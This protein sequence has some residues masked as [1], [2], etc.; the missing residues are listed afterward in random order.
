MTAAET[1]VFFSD[2]D[3]IGP[4]RDALAAADPALLVRTPDEIGAAETVRYALVWKPPLGFFA[5]YPDLG[6]ITILGAG[7]DALA[8]RPDLPP[9]PI[10]RI[11]DPEMARMMCQYVLF[12][13]L[14]HARDI[15]AFEQAQRERRW[16]YI[17]PRPA[18]RIPVGVLGLGELGAAAAIALARQSFP[19]RGWSRSPKSIDGVTT[20]SGEPGLAEV[21]AESEIV[22]VMLPLTAATRHLLD[23]GRLAAMRKGAK[24]VNVSRGAIVDEEALVRSLASGHLGGA[25]LDVFEREPLAPGHPLWAMPNVLITPHLASVAIP[26][27]AAK[28]IAD[29]IARTRQGL[30]IG[31]RVDLDRGY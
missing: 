1:L 29:N 5:R 3:P 24:L 17:H 27:S 18:G 16:H 4:W 20:L 7:A 10:A 14:R 25:T 9:V 13:V 31:Q 8:G 22:V 11:S 23:A 26:H 6:L 28:Q 15:P 30:P 12:A 21:L 2:V 19:V